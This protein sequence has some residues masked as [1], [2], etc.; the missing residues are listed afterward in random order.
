MDLEVS[1]AS[2]RNKDYGRRGFGEKVWRGDP[3]LGNQ[4]LHRYLQTLQW[5]TAKRQTATRW[6]DEVLRFSPSLMEVVKGWQELL[7]SQLDVAESRFNE[8][9][10]ACGNNAHGIKYTSR[11][12]WQV[13]DTKADA[14][15]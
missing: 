3:T 4:R 13:S 2:R 9:I 8:T 10:H 6:S 15:K 5:K 12:G 14:Q 7:E 1:L 11:S